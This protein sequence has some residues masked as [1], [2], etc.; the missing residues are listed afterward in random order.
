MWHIMTLRK[1]TLL[2]IA[3]TV[4]VLMTTIYAILSQVLLKGFTS[5]EYRYAHKDVERFVDTLE[6]SLDQLN[7]HV[8]D[9]AAWDDTYQFIVDEN[10]TYE[11]SN[12]GNQTLH[13]L[14]INLMAFL[15]TSG[16]IVYT[17]MI[18]LDTEKGISLPPELPSLLKDDAILHHGPHVCTGKTGIMMIGNQPMLIAAHPIMTSRCQGPV[19]GTLIIGRYLDWEKIQELN[20]RTH[21]FASVLTLSEIDILQDTEEAHDQISETNPIVSL[22]LSQDSIA[23]YTLL[24]DIHGDPA[25][26]LRVVNWRDIFQQ[27]QTS[28]YYLMISIILI[29]IASGVAIITLLEKVVLSRLAHLSSQVNTIGATGD[30]SDRVDYTGHDELTILAKNI[31]RM[32][33]ALEMAQH[34]RQQSEAR[35]RAVIEQASEGIFLFDVES[36]YIVESNAAFERIFGYNK[37]EI[38][39]LTIYHLVAHNPASID[40]H[41]QRVQ[42]NKRF[43]L[44]ERQYRRK[45][46]N[47]VD[48]EVSSV[49]I[50]FRDR[51]LQC[52]VVRDITDRKQREREMHAIAIVASALRSIPT[53]ARMIHVILEQTEALLQAQDS[54]LMMAI[55]GSN[56]VS[57]ELA[58]GQWATSTGRRFHRT[59]LLEP[60]PDVQ[61]CP[62]SPSPEAVACA[63]LITNGHTIGTLW[64][65]RDTHMS[66][67][68]LRILTAI[69]DIAAAAIHRASLYEQTEHHVKELTTLHAI[70]MAISS[71]LD[72]SS[73]LKVFLDQVIT[74]LPI[75][76]AA[77]ML[78]NPY[79]RT[80]TYASGRG[81]DGYAMEG[82]E[83]RLGEGQAGR[84]AL[85]RHIVTLKRNDDGT[86]YTE[87]D[88]ALYSRLNKPFPATYAVPL[89]AR[90]EVKGVMQLFHRTNF[91]P[92]PEWPDFLEALAAH[93]AIAI[94]NVQLL[95]DLQRSRD[96]LTLT[97]DAT[98][99]GWVRA[100]DLRDK[101]TEGHSQRVT[102][103]T[104]RLAEAM[105]MSNAE[106]MHVRRGALLHD[107][108]KIGIPDS[109]LLKAGPLNPEE[110]K[111]MRKHPEYA[112]SMLAPITYLRPAL[113]I[114][115]CHH[116]RWDGTGYP[117]GLKGEEIP[118]AARIFAV[119]DV[120]DALLSDRPYRKGWNPE[121]VYEHIESRAGNHFDPKVVEAFLELV[122]AER[123]IH[124]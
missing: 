53:R 70:D 11:Q 6:V 45:D 16:S 119:V 48:V 74:H 23:G 120:W 85:E 49:H 51:D 52:A 30:L 99:E 27:G 108:G 92:D 116:E 123:N 109:I 37:D 64:I 83:C 105:G 20:K 14:E 26:M 90:G 25:L 91:D 88:Y 32:L 67:T 41:I 93:T 19:R 35:Y 46:G 13:Y 9:W 65:G 112:Y 50:S 114:P 66:R 94:D 59:D 79:M 33:G 75:D 102:R 73:M 22:P 124:I 80:L 87:P 82:F 8:R 15:D 10:K 103:M 96:E 17:K 110:Q 36:H 56:A 107:I 18:D 28:L 60:N 72:L 1:K 89:I 98:L 4:I 104:V 77:L 78:Y 21:V 38:R 55:P 63:P 62:L 100:L 58:H 47:L 12:L 122:Q 111:L 81:E 29:S 42:Q 40:Q 68:E 3:I 117:R 31:N 7:A 86:W 24:Q 97:Y 118:L 113:D 44:G 121:D 71:T 115:Y 54:A 84:A 43:F 2:T 106:L 101:E 34:E 61:F 95:Q 39:Q 5:L 57:V 76:G 69:G